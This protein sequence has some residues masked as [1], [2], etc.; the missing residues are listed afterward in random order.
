MID[1]RDHLWDRLAEMD[2]TLRHFAEQEQYF[3]EHQAELERVRKEL[4]KEEAAR[5]LQKERDA[6]RLQRSKEIDDANNK[7]KNLDEEIDKANKKLDAA[8]ERME[9]QELD[10]NQYLAL[11]LEI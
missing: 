7:I 8:Y 5:K 1:R 9:T 10:R 2:E 3:K 4:A 6:I 11:D